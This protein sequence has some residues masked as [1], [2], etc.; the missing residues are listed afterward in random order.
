MQQRAVA[1]V[2]RADHDAAALGLDADDVEPLAVGDMQAAPL[3]HGEAGGAVVAA[4]QAAVDVDDLAGLERVGPQTRHHVAVVAAGH[5]ADVLAV[6]L[7]GD[8]EA[9][10]MG[11]GADGGLVE[12]AQREAQESQLLGG[13]REQEIALVLGRVGGAMQLGAVRAR[14]AASIVAGGERGRTQV[15]GDAQKIA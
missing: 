1:G 6:R 15:A 10:A 2:A 14:L 11:V 8:G 7:G 13:G 9:Q 12:A 4:E 3:A 5:E